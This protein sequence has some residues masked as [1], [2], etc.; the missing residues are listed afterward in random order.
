ELVETEVLHP[1]LPIEVTD[2]ISPRA[3]GPDPLKPLYDMHRDI[4]SALDRVVDDTASRR[5]DLE[6]LRRRLALHDD[7]MRRVV[8]PMARRYGGAAGDD[9]TWSAEADETDAEARLRRLG[10]L[11][12]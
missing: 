11:C 7:V 12:Q 8:H 1:E 3:S 4:R 9:A 5:D 6:V 2:S 10:L